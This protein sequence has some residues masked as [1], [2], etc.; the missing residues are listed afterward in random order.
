VA[1]LVEGVR[2]V[3]ALGGTAAFSAVRAEET[4]PGGDT[5]SRA[6]I[7]AF[8]RRAADTIYHP[9]GTCRMGPDER[10]V[11]DASLRVHGVEN[12]RVA[13]ASV[14]PNVVNGNTHAACVMIGERAADLLTQD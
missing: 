5:R 8:I 6:E 4:E 2:L 14:M 3:R 12:L 1:A 10:A 11:V 9:A 7:E 13:D